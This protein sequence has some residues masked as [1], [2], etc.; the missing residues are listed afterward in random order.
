MK[1]V[2]NLAVVA[3]I[4]LSA[5]L[6]TSSCSIGLIGAVF[7]KTKQPF[8]LTMNETGTKVG[9]SKALSV[10]NIVAIGDWG[11]NEAI[12]KGNIKKVSH[13]DVEVFSVLGLFTTYKTF[14]YGN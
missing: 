12:K 2:T 11:Y 7:T 8:A 5:A 1:K 13:V 3:I 9:S 4:A 6:F 10:L 14:V